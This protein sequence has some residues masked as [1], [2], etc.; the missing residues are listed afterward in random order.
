MKKQEQNKPYLHPARRNLV[1]FGVP[2]YL[3]LVT[4]LI[5]LSVWKID[6][7]EYFVLSWF[8]AVCAVLFLA[9]SA[10]MIWLSHRVF[11]KEAET[12]RARY[13][14]LL[15]P[16]KPIDL[17]KERVTVEDDGVR[18]IFTELGLKIEDETVKSTGQVFEEHDSGKIILWKNADVY[19]ATR[20]LERRVTIA[21]AV[22]SGETEISA[23]VPITESV[24]SAVCALGLDKDFGEGW[25]YLKYNPKDAFRQLLKRGYIRE[26]Y[27]AK[28]GEMFVD[29]YG[30]FLGDETV[31][32]SENSNEAENK[33][34]R[35]E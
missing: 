4:F 15:S 18:Y 24:Y 19:L 21:L 13:A 32:T 1:L 35:D 2:T 11:L 31:M 28:T 6:T 9:L 23:F 20:N 5:L 30:N 8:T 25:T 16:P 33:N 14:Y 3:V 27:N 29:K 10:G 7:G 34:A 22:Y 26:M 17:S 12:E